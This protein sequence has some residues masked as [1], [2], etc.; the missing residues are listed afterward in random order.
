M[1]NRVWVAAAALAVNSAYLAATATAS[2]FYF[3]NIILHIGLG[4]TLA[5]AVTRRLVRRE[6][7]L[8]LWTALVGAPLA[9]GALSG[10]A[11][12][13]VGATR[14]WRWLLTAH[15]VSSVAGSVLLAAWGLAFAVRQTSTR[16]RF[17]LAGGV[18]LLV[19]IAAIAAS[20]AVRR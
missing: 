5:V 1:S 4:A 10:G 13:I 12:A 3:A 9:I 17:R 2:L 7:R 8:N 14:P 11:L 15:I 20:V 19:L 18:L 6:L 16:V